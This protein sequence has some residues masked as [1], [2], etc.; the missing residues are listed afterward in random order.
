MKKIIY[1]LFLF[2]VSGI[3]VFA[4]S[5]N[6]F[7]YQGVA[8]SSTGAPLVSI[9]IGMRLT[10]HDGSS[11]GTIV[12]QETQTPITNAF[13]LYN[14]AVGGGTVVSG[15][16]SAINWGS[17]AKYLQVELD[18]AGGTA[19]TSIGSTQLLSVPYALYSAHAGGA[20]SGVTSVVAGAGLSGGTITTTG[21]IS[22][23]NV[24]TPG[25]YGSNILIPIIRTDTQGRII[26]VID[27]PVLVPVVSGS[28]SHLA[29]FT[30]P[31]SVG[32]SNLID[33][34]IGL[35]YNAA[36]YID[37]VNTKLFY[38]AKSISGSNN[39]FSFQGDDNS[40]DFL[41]ISDSGVG[42]R[43]LI[44]TSSQNLATGFT[45]DNNSALLVHNPTTN[46]LHFTNGTSNMATLDM[47]YGNFN[48]TGLLSKGGGSFKIDHPLDPENKYL[49]HSFVESPDM[50]N[51]YNGNIVTDADGYAE[52]NLPDYFDA[53]N[54]DCRYQLT[55]I[56]T[57]AQAIISEKVH[58]N[59]FKIKTNI[60]NVEVSWQVT[61]IRKDKFAQAHRIIPV[62]NKEQKNKGK[63]LHP[64]EYGLPASK[65]IDYGIKVSK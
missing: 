23:P 27:T 7:N 57:F 25:V 47:T 37:P 44:L 46:V 54:S 31:N 26:S 8:R 33:S 5:P 62:V 4:Q 55:A 28:A 63:Y 6:L 17:G 51:I 49:Y 24:G 2:L 13:G 18:P 39:W 21:T 59:I 34:S 45:T 53:L 35:F 42:N 12:Y 58:G 9:T 41:T 10:I 3:S 15:T 38:R 30:G 1:S 11:T 60:P 29:K 32:N 20:G 14:V 36:S 64:T 50:M 52:V 56:G 48:V 61:G 65:G 43:G 22:M 16:F 40:Y 19:Y